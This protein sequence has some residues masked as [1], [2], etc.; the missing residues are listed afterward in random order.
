LLIRR[1]QHFVLLG[2][3]AQSES[4]K[5]WCLLIA[6]GSAIRLR[7]ETFAD[8][9]RKAEPA[10]IQKFLYGF[11]YTKRLPPADPFGFNERLLF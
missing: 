1:P 6:H 7:R 10:D 3:Y 4:R 11:L 5:N 9:G 8:A 2:C